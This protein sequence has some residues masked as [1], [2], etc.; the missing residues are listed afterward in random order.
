MTKIERLRAAVAGRP[1]DRPP[2]TVWYHFGLQHAPP[3]RTA[4]AHLELYDA[5]DLDWLKLM[6]GYSYPMPPGV[7]TLDEPRELGKVTPLEVERTP[8]AE[9]WRVIEIVA[10][11]LRGRAL[12]VDTVFNAWNTLRRN[13]VKRAMDAFMRDHPRALEAALGAVNETLIRRHGP[14]PVEPRRAAG[15]GHRRVAGGRPRHARGTSANGGPAA[16]ER[17]RLA[18]GGPPDHLGAGG[19]SLPKRGRS[20]LPDGCRAIGGRRGR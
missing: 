8:L 6:N 2:F 20:R 12:F 7:E 9:Q 5:Y 19:R 15:D 4:H 14:L 13:V 17:G 18:R 11:A 1:V 16:R 3:E 10:P